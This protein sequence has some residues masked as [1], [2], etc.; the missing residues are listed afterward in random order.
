MPDA[1][2]PSIA[3]PSNSVTAGVCVSPNGPTPS[4]Q[5][6]WGAAA[7]V[8][9][10][11]TD[12]GR[13]VTLRRLLPGQDRTADVVGILDGWDDD[14]L[15]VT[16]R[17]GEQVQIPADTVIA[18]KVVAPEVSSAALQERC[19]ADWTPHEVVGLNGW[20]LRYHFGLNRRTCSVLAVAPPEIPW[21]KQLD[22]VRAWY[23]A[24]HAAPL[25]LSIEGS[26]TDASLAARSLPVVLRSAVLVARTSSVIEA[27][28][29]AEGIAFD[30]GSTPPRRFLAL[31]TDTASD[32]EPLSILLAGAPGSSYAVGSIDGEPLAS[33]RVHARGGWAGL[34]HLEVD[35]AARRRG[36]G[37][38]L[39]GVLARV[40][41]DAGA[42]D[43][44]LQVDTENAAAIAMYN[45]LG[46]VR[47][48]GY[49]Y[50]AVS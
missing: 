35:Q 40:A 45:R 22:D 6:R 7:S 20:T 29:R 3:V 8:R 50:R 23:H 10:D 26:D 2:R 21:D 32:L 25:T 42:V 46:F 30:V 39:V 4:P 5:L 14:T 34:T 18:G 17:S 9:F 19:A 24:R 36:I 13:R 43:L 48:H 28:S 38:M 12:I 15:A 33:G 11:R 16:R 47:H 44:W 37:S 27:T 1:S 41:A 31:N 49:L